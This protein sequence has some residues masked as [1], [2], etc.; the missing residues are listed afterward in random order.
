MFLIRD[1]GSA[2]R[3]AA[4]G[5]QIVLAT[6]LGA[7]LGF[8]PGF[9]LPGDVGGGFLQA[10]G[11]ILALSIAALVLDTNLL[12]FGLATL[13]AKLASIALLPVSFE[14]GRFLLEGPLEGVFRNLVNGPVTAWFGLEYYATTGG[15]AVGVAL[16]LT[17][18]LTVARALQGLRRSMAGVEAGSERYQSLVGRRSV[19]F[20]AWLFFGS[21]RKRSW[22]DSAARGRRIRIVRPIGAIAALVLLGSVYAVQESLG[23]AWLGEKS[24]YSLAA[25][26]GATVDLDA[27][28]LDL[29]DGRVKFSGLAMSDPEDLDRDAFRARTLDFDLSMRDLLAGSVAIDRIQSGDAETGA[30][31]GKPGRRIHPAPE[32][33]PAPAPDQ[34]GRPLEDYLADFEIWKQRLETASEWLE[35]FTGA[36]EDVPAEEPVEERDDRIAEEVEVLGL[37]RV[38]AAHFRTDSPA[39]TVREL[40]LDGVSVAG[41]GDDRVDVRGENL[42]SHPTLAGAPSLLRAAA[43]SGAFR[44]ELRFDPARPG[45]A[46]VSVEAKGLQ[47][48]DLAASLRELPVRGG[49][50]DLSLDG[51]VEVRAD[52][53]HLG[54]PLMAVLRDTEIQVGSKSAKLDRLELPIGLSGPLR[55][56]AVEVDASRFADALT[57]AGR[58][59]LADEVRAR[60]GAIVGGELGDALGGV[61]DG[62]KSTEEVVDQAKQKAEDELKKRAAE[63]LNKRLPG[64]LGGLLKKKN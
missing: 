32:K 2:V 7:M 46:S 49:V 25:W 34:P 55:S 62:T 19:R 17:V 60:A 24:R 28:S 64:G 30:A 58:A 45:A 54:L 56:P 48:Q 18:G 36:G 6:T 15:V 3:G 47:L 40:V 16:G 23:G 27:A 42:S 38:A 8:V 13:G 35:K 61:I 31:R 51:E 52:G 29:A 11:L 33:Q 22:A 53:I 43:Q 63:E 39:V 12:V 20:L 9:F 37:A 57:A 10:P 5:P 26:N 1:L 21:A 59:E 41:L 50:V 44:F 14:V 4:T